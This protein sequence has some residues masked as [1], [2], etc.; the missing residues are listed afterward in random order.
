MTET[1]HSSVVDRAADYVLRTSRLLERRRFD[2][3]FNGG[4]ADAV[5]AALMP[6]RNPDGGFGNALEPDCRAP[7][8]QPVTTM[9]ALTFLDEVGA[10]SG[11]LGEGICDY[12]SSVS[13]PDGG[14]PFAHPS[15]RGFPL[16][17][18]WQIPDSYEGSLIPTGTICGLLHKNNL[19]HPWLAPAAEFCW[20][21]IDAIADT[22]PYEVLA[23]LGFLD[24]CP[25][26]DRARD[27][28]DRLGRT[29]RK[30]QLVRI[31]G[32]EPVPEGYTAGELM[33]PH[34][35]APRPESIARQWFSAAELESSLDAL[36]QEQGADGGW[37]VRWRIWSPAIAHEWGGWVTI[38]ALLILKAHGRLPRTVTG[39]SS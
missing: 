18:W 33:Y 24:H 1:L 5:L 26:R 30:G 22:H 21:R 34:D 29:V 16:A 23:C 20:G 38:E 28:A 2:F 14:V 19:E 6:Y 32:D 11:E 10:V 15:A 39:S 3:H 35:Y 17:P 25:D 36:A 8:S 9:G 13:A 12:L 4:S 7:G 37:P 31:S 27:A